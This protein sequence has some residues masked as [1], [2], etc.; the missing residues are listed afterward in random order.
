MLHPIYDPDRIP[1]MIRESLD[2]YA[3]HGVPPGDCLRAILSGDLF[4]AYARADDETSSA[5]P[6]IVRYV[7][8]R[9][10]AG[11]FG[12]RE[13]VADWLATRLSER[14]HGMGVVR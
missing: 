4:L 14:R 11:S 1:P 6:A 12:S 5:M 7:E 10:P 3:K 2:C 9:L 13:L 8:E